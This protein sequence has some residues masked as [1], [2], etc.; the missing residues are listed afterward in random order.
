MSTTI[1]TSGSHGVNG[2]LN[3]SGTVKAGAL[4]SPIIKLNGTDISTA[5]S[6]VAATETKVNNIISG[7]QAVGVATKITTSTVS[8]T[9][10]SSYG[11][12]FGSNNTNT[13]PLQADTISYTPKAP[14]SNLS[15][16]NLGCNVV[17][18]GK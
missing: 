4:D 8:S 3:A 13:N 9:S 11:L 1:S 7:S 5:L 17:T 10:T 15:S 12:I 16:L 6:G 14:I 18:L 2:D